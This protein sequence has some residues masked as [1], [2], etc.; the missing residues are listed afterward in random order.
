MGDNH[1][2]FLIRTP[3]A[4]WTIGFQELEIVPRFEGNRSLNL[5]NFPQKKPILRTFPEIPW[6]IARKVR[7]IIQN[8]L[9]SSA[10]LKIKG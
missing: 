5:P 6:K 4:I 2:P 9:N 10:K 7:E 8:H 1:S 3:N